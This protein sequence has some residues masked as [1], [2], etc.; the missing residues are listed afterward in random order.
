[1]RPSRN[2]GNAYIS[3]GFLTRS[4]FWFMKTR[5]EFMPGINFPSTPP[6]SPYFDPVSF[7]PVTRISRYPDISSP[8]WN[9][10]LKNR[11]DKISSIFLL[12][13][14][15]HE[16]ASNSKLSSFFFICYRK[17]RL[18]VAV[19]PHDGQRNGELIL[20]QD[21]RNSRM[22]IERRH[23]DVFFPSPPF[24]LRNWPARIL[25][26]KSGIT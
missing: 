18:P 3:V 20:V 26:D 23:F 11:P 5:R 15:F 7:F 21:R 14:S 24:L 17:I 10:A 22:K 13:F 9:G 12:L 2:A 4:R 6:P 25:E 1:M 16:V 8:S 19:W